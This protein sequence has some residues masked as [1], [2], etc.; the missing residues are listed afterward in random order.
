MTW[1]GLLLPASFFVAAAKSSWGSFELF[2][3]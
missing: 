3:I 2:P 1:T